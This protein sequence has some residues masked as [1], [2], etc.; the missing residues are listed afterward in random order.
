MIFYCVRNEKELLTVCLTFSSV[1]PTKRLGDYRER[2][3]PVK[4]FS[5]E[6]WNKALT[7]VF[8]PKITTILAMEGEIFL[9]IVVLIV[10]LGAAVMISR[11]KPKLS[12][13]DRQHFQQQ[14]AATASLDPAHSVLESH[15]IF[16]TALGQLLG[17]RGTKLMAAERVRRFQAR[18]PNAK[19]VWVS[20]RLRNR[21][22][23]ETGIQVSAVQA[24]QARANFSRAL[25]ALSR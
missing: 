18:F 2:R 5:S 24:E 19:H 12:A 8:S 23:H 6:F 1:Y 21:I 22:A 14:I 3:G 25:G 7:V 16:I 10:L 13:G 17:D 20:H 15:K 11:R 9:G 4:F